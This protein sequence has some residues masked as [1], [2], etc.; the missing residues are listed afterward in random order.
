MLLLVGTGEAANFAAYAFAP[1]SL[2]TPLGALSVLVTAVL[3]SRYLKENLNLLSKVGCVL[4]VLGSTV[5]VIHAPKERQIDSLDSIGLMLV[6]PTFVAYLIF[7]CFTSFLLIAFY[8]PKY[9][10]ENVLIYVMICSLIGSLSVMSCK[11]LGVAIRQTLTQSNQMTNSLFWVFLISVITTVSIQMNYLNKSLD[12]FDTTV[13]TPI[14]YVFFTTFVIIASAILFKEWHSMTSEDIIASFCGFLIVIIA[15]FL[16]NAFKD[17]KITIESL[18]SHWMLRK[19]S[20][21]ANGL[22]SQSQV[23]LLSPEVRCV[24]PPGLITWTEADEDE[25]FNH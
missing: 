8:A 4:C 2:V 24:I 21:T 12:I 6:E 22:D 17:F 11:G 5:I 1:A 25:L 15:I 19:A 18:R 7:V 9:G 10:S 3:A 14:Y 13:V 23:K 16:L 20:L